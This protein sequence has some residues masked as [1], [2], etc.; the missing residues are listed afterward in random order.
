M[1]RVSGRKREVKVLRQEQPEM[2]QGQK[3][4]CGSLSSGA[5]WSVEQRAAEC[6]RSIEK[7]KKANW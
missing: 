3:D 6:D 1:R 4:G 7:T 5:V 2:C